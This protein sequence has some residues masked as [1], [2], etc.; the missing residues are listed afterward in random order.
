MIT[1]VPRRDGTPPAPEQ[2]RR[3]R[4]AFELARAE[5]RRHLRHPVLW[6]GIAATIYSFRQSRTIDWT[7]GAYSAFP[8]DFV[9]CAW[10]MFV[11]GAISGGRDHL[12]GGRTAPGA[13]SPGD[14]VRALGRLLSLLAPLGIA[15]AV[16]AGVVITMRIEGGYSIGERGWGT[17][18]AQ[19]TWPEVLQPV[20]LFAACG[21]TG[22]GM[23]RTVRQGLV[24]I[25]TGT[26]A[27]FAFGLVAWAWQWSPAVFLTPVQT[28]PFSVA[29]E[30]GPATAHADWWLA[31]PGQHQEGWRRL[32]VDPVMA[33]WHDVV[34]LGAGVAGVGWAL[35]GTTGRRLAI[36]GAALIAIGA[37]AQA[38]AAPW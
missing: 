26:V 37:V 7:A 21:A 5:A 1:V 10:A 32:V 23:G 20:L 25:V 2:E 6:L 11:L 33:I 8:T 19:P 34:L 27:L 22:V 16:V 30:G 18:S 29:L 17:S 12:P 36:V 14:A 9:G 38:V 31:A 15:A 13:A 28:Q 3:T 24:T 35:T 4:V